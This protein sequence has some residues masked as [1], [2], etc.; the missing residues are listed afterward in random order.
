[1]ACCIF[2]AF[3]FSQLYAGYEA[4]LAY[5]GKTPGD[6]RQQ[7]INWR[8]DAN[9]ATA[10]TVATPIPVRAGRW[11]PPRRALLIAVAAELVLLGLTGAWFTAGGG[12]NALSRQLTELSQVRSLAELADFC[13]F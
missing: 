2:V 3:I 5:F 7:E 4:L 10:A 1:M 9:G 13:G 6:R 12:W 11:R 8:L